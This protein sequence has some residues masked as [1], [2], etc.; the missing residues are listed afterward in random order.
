MNLS[1]LAAIFLLMISG[2]AVQQ[3]RKKQATRK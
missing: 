2:V 1:A 3:K